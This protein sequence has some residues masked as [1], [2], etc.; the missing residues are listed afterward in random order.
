MEVHC[1]KCG[2]PD[3]GRCLACREGIVCR[4]CGYCDHPECDLHTE[5][6]PSRAVDNRR[7]K[8]KHERKKKDKKTKLAD[9]KLS[10]AT[11]TSE[12]STKLLVE[13]MRG[14]GAIVACHWLGDKVL[15]VRNPAWPEDAEIEDVL[16]DTLPAESKAQMRVITRGV[17]NGT[18][19]T[20]RVYH[21]DY[22]PETDVS[23][24]AYDLPSPDS[25]LDDPRQLL[26]GLVV[27][28][29]AVV[30]PDGSLPF[31]AFDG[32]TA[33]WTVWKCAGFRFEVTLSF[34]GLSDSSDDHGSVVRLLGHHVLLADL[35]DGRDKYGTYTNEGEASAVRSE[36]VGDHVAKVVGCPHN[37]IPL[38]LW[39]SLFRNTYSV[40][41]VSH[42]YVYE[43]ATPL[44]AT[45][46]YEG[47][48]TELAFGEGMLRDHRWAPPVERQPELRSVVRYGGPNNKNYAP[49]SAKQSREI[50]KTTRF[51]DE[52]I[53]DVDAV[54]SVPQYLW[55]MT[56][57]RTM[58]EPSLANALHLR[59]T[60]FVI[61]WIFAAAADECRKAT[62]GFYREWTAAGCD[63]DLIPRLFL[64][65]FGP[66]GERKPVLSVRPDVAQVLGI[67][68]RQDEGGAIV[69]IGTI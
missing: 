55:M 32:P 30:R 67:V 14:E 28:N 35:S 58:A 65:H 23:R 37:V 63:P 60:W 49:Y 52:S 1:D 42:G 40:L 47:V 16:A 57:C 31:F 68:G 64:D 69:V 44:S 36:I 17:P 48:P 13:C 11:F 18:A 22:D 45:S 8:S 66:F 41:N 7:T 62:T 25:P 56:S 19:A 34:G 46:T 54:P 5:E 6:V 51:G 38:N 3:T 20:I 9:A 21:V 33:S 53:L 27:R 61:G 12:S 43:R 4:Q 2:S 59:G 24:A 50:S 10:N 15:P 29:D 26:E 39:G